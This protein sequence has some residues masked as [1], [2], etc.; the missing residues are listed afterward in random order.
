MKINKI[1]EEGEQ[2]VFFFFFCFIWKYLPREILGIL[3][4]INYEKRYKFKKSRNN[5]S[6]GK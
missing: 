3:I 1:I 2:K 5:S 4:I 6:M